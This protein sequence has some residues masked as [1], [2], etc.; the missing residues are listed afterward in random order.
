MQFMKWIGS[1]GLAL[2]I[3]VSANA[4]ASGQAD[5]SLFDGTLAQSIAAVIVFLIL[6]AVLTKFAWGSILQGLQDREAKI[7][8]DLEQAQEAAKQ[9]ADTLKE[10]QVK[11][12]AAQEE[13][14]G[15]ID[16]GR[17]DAQSIASKLKEQ[18]QKDAQQLQQRSRDEIR[19]AKEQAIQE[20]YAQAADLSVAVAEKILHRQ[21][22][23]QDHQ[24][25]IEQS[26]A[27]LAGQDS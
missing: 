20:I 23:A 25:I 7:K 1:T 6:F 15:I 26:L 5:P 24:Q 19:L 4:E 21:L 3:T 10:Y 2:L 27:E 11:L 9:A 8:K 18:A 14:K 16:Q 13:A 22:N 17:S 12:A